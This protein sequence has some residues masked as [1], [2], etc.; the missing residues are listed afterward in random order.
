MIIDIHTHLGDILHEGGGSLIGKTGVRKRRIFDPVSISE[1]MLHRDIGFNRALERL[2]ERW[3]VNAEQ[4]R[5]ATATLE[6][7]TRSM[8]EEGIAYSAAM[9][10][11][12]YVCFDD[13]SRAQ[14][15]EKRLIP[16]T[17]VD[18]TAARP[19]GRLARDVA[20]GARG[21]KLHPIIQ[22]VALVD[23]RT[24][25]AVEC[26]SPFGLPV[27]LHCGHTSY[28]HRAEAHRQDTSLGAIAHVKELAKAF[29][30]VRFIA[31]H[32]GLFEV[33]ETIELLAPLP[34]V[35]AEVS[36]QPPAII[37]RLVAAFGPDRVLYGSDWPWGSRLT[38][39]AAVRAACRGDAGLE[40][41]ILGENAAALLGITAG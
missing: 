30:K 9:P 2:L 27:L 5:N 6:N 13:L 15:L 37:R 35:Y 31:G 19:S 24:M 22:R 32:S 11:P 3:V 16:F 14:R 7:M 20:A 28:F 21:L 17:G 38:A 8:N 33:R 25:E 18:F 12:P 34:N 29:P 23:R 36:F 41:A 26:F 4:A 39:L 10:I 40:R 1:S